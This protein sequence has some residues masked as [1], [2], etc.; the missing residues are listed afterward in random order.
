MITTM[1]PVGEEQVGCTVTLATGVAGAPAG[2]LTINTVAVDTQLRSTML[3][4]VTL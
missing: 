1:V 3:L 2:G 4:A